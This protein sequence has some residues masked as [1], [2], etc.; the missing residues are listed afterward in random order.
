MLAEPGRP[1]NKA[2]W[3]WLS[4]GVGVPAGHG[5]DPELA[6]DTTAPAGALEIAHLLEEARQSEPGF[7][8]VAVGLE[9]PAELAERSEDIVVPTDQNEAA[10]FGGFAQ[11]PVSPYS[12]YV[13]SLLQVGVR[14]V[15][16]VSG[17][18]HRITGHWGESSN[19]SSAFFRICRTEEH[20]ARRR[21]IKQSACRALEIERR[22][23]DHF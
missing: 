21:P 13:L 19:F 9:A 20:C 16:S 22:F 12:P 1:V 3:M 23:H 8:G 2:G 5:E 11:W 10:S 6:R 4:V 15:G 18:F 17:S 7:V 14:M